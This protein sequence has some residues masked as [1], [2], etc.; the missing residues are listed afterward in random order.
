MYPVALRPDFT[1]REL[2]NFLSKG[3]GSRA[4]QK[5]LDS[6]V[7]RFKLALTAQNNLPH[8]AFHRC[9]L[10]CA[11]KFSS[12]LSNEKPHRCCRAKLTHTHIHTANRTD[13]ER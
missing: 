3:S 12:N 6:Y 7:Q 10:F 1:P 13:K 9:V 11:D 5:S 4:A 8:F 2:H